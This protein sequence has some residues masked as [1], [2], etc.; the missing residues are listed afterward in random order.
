MLTKEN[1]QDIY[2]LTPMQE[3]MLLD[4]ARNPDSAAYVEQFDFVLEGP[5]EIGA[6][7]RAFGAIVAK[8]SALRTLF[9]FRKTDV[10]RQ[11]VL[12]SRAPAVEHR[13]FGAW[14]EDAALAE[15][16]HCKQTDRD[17]GFNIS[18]DLL[19][20]L[21]VF[22]LGPERHRM[23][24]TFHHIILDGWCFGPLFEDFFSYYDRLRVDSVAVIDERETVPYGVYIRWL[25][26]QDRA[27]AHE[28]WTRALAGYEAEAGPPYFNLAYEGPVSSDEYG[29]S[30]GADLTAEIQ[31]VARSHHLTV[32]S[33]F[34]T[35]WGVLLQ[36][37]NHVDDVVFGT[38]VS[39]RPAELAGVERMVGLFIN[40][41][42]LRVA[43]PR[44]TA[45]IELARRVHQDIFAAA[46]YEYYP[47]AAVQAASPLKSRLINHVV[48]FENLPISQQMRL[49]SANSRDLRV[50]D[51]HVHQAAKFDFH[52]IVFPGADMRLSFVYNAHRYARQTM[53]TLARSLQCLLTAIAARPHAPLKELSIC[54]EDD[55]R[56]VLDVFNSTQRDYP[57]QQSIPALFEQVAQSRGDA[58]ALREGAR[59]LSYRVLRQQALALAAALSEAGVAAGEHVGLLA[60]RGIDLVLGMLATLYCGAAYVPLETQAPEKRLAALLGDAG[61]RVVGVPPGWSGRLPEGVNALPLEPTLH[62]A[63]PGFTPR[64]PATDQA[65]YVMYTSGSTGLPKGCIV[66]HRNVVRLVRNTDYVELG[67]E[68][69]I[70]QTGAPA[71]DAST[72]EVWGALL[73]GGELVLVDEATLLDARLLRAALEQHRVTVLWLTQALFNQLCEADEHMFGGLRTLLVGGD[74]LSPR[75]IERVRAASPGLRIVNGYGPTE[76]TTF[77]TTFLIDR[78]YAQRIPI[79]RP[80]A[81]SRAYILDAGG[82]LLPPGACGELCVGGDGVALGYL[83]RPEL[84]Q[85]KFGLDPFRSGGPTA[86]A[87]PPL[88]VGRLYRT[89]DIAR[90]L[91]DGTLDMLGRNDF[92]V[93]IRGFRVELGEIERALA[94]HPGITDVVVVAHERA[95]AQGGDKQLHAFYT[96]PADVAPAALREHLSALPSY[97]VPGFFLRLAQMPLTVNGKLDRRALPVLQSLAQAAQDP[98]ALQPIAPRS[99]TESRIAQICCEVLGVSAIGVHDNFFE[100][101]ANS[102]NLIAINNRLQEA[103]ARDIPLAMLFEYTSIARLAEYLG[104][105]PVAEQQRRAAEAQALDEAQSALKRTRNLIKSMD[106]A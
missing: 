76:N 47:L 69:R 11:V 62:A 31:R 77:S 73:N 30:L 93:K 59:V 6:V 98:A 9:S 96:G 20:R 13:D 94:R 14:E 39:G 34:Q 38:V 28:H 26:Q 46:A 12:K 41:Q 72:F 60:P 100:A 99:Q 70:L 101:G 74:T 22:S 75:H 40:T 84:T 10:P 80:I 86:T 78:P 51:V 68:Q 65:A 29:L 50:T 58:V 95:G 8:Y 23:V 97:M 88:P 63:P 2:P 3:G 90:W 67:P 55:R 89:G 18:S 19:V 52:L 36:K 17:R 87:A 104:A 45:F 106:D 57:A 71:F 21:S 32:N 15:V 16:D 105:D 35:A 79:G 103:F 64:L 92:Q 24:L 25:G 49:L 85:E 81:N 83:N 5:L 82:A 48:T 54:A 66:T 4:Y 44:E 33:L 102:L 53:A 91:P 7:R 1:V 61:V 27:C 42:P 56:R 37:Y 43:A